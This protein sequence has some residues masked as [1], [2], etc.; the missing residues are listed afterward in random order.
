MIKTTPGV[1]LFICSSPPLT[2]TNSQRNVHKSQIHDEK[3]SWIGYVRAG[4]KLMGITWVKQII[5]YVAC[6]TS[7]DWLISRM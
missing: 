2:H 7:F 6:N 5:S 1:N 4:F 3:D